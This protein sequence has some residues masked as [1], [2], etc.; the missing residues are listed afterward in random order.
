MLNILVPIRGGE[1]LRVW[2]VADKANISITRVAGSL[3]V[4]KALDLSRF[5]L[6]AAAVAWLVV[7]PTTVVEPIRWA[8][9]PGVAALALLSAVLLMRRVQVGWASGTDRA[10]GEI[11]RID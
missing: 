3:G 9:I 6:S 4:E 1:L 2:A 5:G 8:L 7:V 11:T 10:G